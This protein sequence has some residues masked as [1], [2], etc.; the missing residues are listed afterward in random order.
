MTTPED[1]LAALGLELPPPMMAPPGVRLP[2]A[3]INVREGRALISGHPGTG[4]DGNISGPHG[5]VGQDMSTRE[6]MDEARGVGLSILSNF[7]AEIG[8]LSRVTG[9]VR[10]FGM[11]NSAPGYT[12][13][14]VVLNGM[15]D[16]IIDV[17]GP[18][19]G[20]HA[21]SAIGVAGLP[22]GLAMEIE[23]E[24]LIAP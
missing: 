8:D 4:P 21:R 10:V 6:A 3:F 2:F 15:S 5:V 18:E 1:R 17:F 13:Q 9:W 20:R 7:K 23:G 11:V 24:V 12:E 14:H 22:M 16:L 19:I